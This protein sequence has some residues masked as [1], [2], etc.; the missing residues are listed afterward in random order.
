ME[1]EAI[2]RRMVREATIGLVVLA[3]LVGLLFLTIWLKAKSIWSDASEDLLT[4]PVNVYTL[5]RGNVLVATKKPSPVPL[6]QIESNEIVDLGEMRPISSERMAAM[7]GTMSD[8]DKL[9]VAAVDANIGLPQFP[10]PV[11]PGLPS[12]GLPSVNPQPLSPQ[13]SNSGT[14]PDAPLPNDA[15]SS[16]GPNLP[17]LP[18][19][20]G[21][22]EE[23][24][25]AALPRIGATAVPEVMLASSVANKIVLEDS[26]EQ[27]KTNEGTTPI[28]FPSPALPSPNLSATEPMLKLAEPNVAGNPA[29][30]PT[31]EKPT[32]MPSNSIDPLN[33]ALQ[34][35]AAEGHLPRVPA[36]DHS[37]RLDDCGHEP[38]NPA[39]PTPLL[40]NSSSLTQID[41]H[42]EGDAEVAANPAPRT[43]SADEL[44]KAMR[45]VR[46]PQDMTMAQLSNR[47]YG[48]ARYAAALQQL[49][50]RRADDRGRFL[51]DTQIAYL[52]GE[53][54]A[55]VYPD[56]IPADQ[57]DEELGT[58]Q[59]V[60]Y[61]VRPSDSW[62][63]ATEPPR[64]ANLPE[65][66]PI[67]I[68]TAQTA[69]TK[70][71]E[72]V[73]TEGGESLFQLAVDH[74]DQAS[75]YLYLYEWNRATIEGRYRATDPLPKG[76]RIRLTPPTVARTPQG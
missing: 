62:D 22:A 28:V 75:Y 7:F 40:A 37:S 57:F 27:P 49:N 2:D 63:I 55:F 48:N 31:E 24:P 68:D 3:A 10:T 50:H 73:L 42:N 47:L 52:P 66:L 43:Y 13:F 35:A 20:P 34:R 14:L 38:S 71:P 23:N 56:L 4:A 60:D 51:P 29:G 46:L 74:F 11:S 16:G 9:R 39:D 70:T 25:P 17:S 45:R 64:G 8:P 18:S 59:P 32:S 69:A 61:Q 19:L 33:G 6:P 54:L 44:K 26:D 30:A 5:D 1:S 15:N 36:G 41:V 12:P 76:L 65:P 53:M 67:E 21:T 72:W 58:I